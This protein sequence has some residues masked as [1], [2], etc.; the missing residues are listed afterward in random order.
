MESYSRKMIL[1]CNYLQVR[2]S[3]DPPASLLLALVRF[4]RCLNGSVLVNSKYEF[5]WTYR[6]GALRMAWKMVCT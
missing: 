3:E 5:E 6:V 4:E 1:L 2:L